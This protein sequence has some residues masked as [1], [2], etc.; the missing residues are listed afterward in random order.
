VR[1]SPLPEVDRVAAAAPTGPAGDGWH[2]VAAAERIGRPLTGWRV[3]GLPVALYRRTDGSPVAVV[4]RCPHLWVPLSSTGRVVGDDLECR[5]HGL[6]F[7]SH[8]PAIPNHRY[9]TVPVP[10]RLEVL[11]VAEHDGWV[12]IRRQAHGAAGTD[13]MVGP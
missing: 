3:D 4:D 8:G 5:L 12:W 7:D 13:D 6:R 11:E 10:Y 1:T 9:R 2:Q